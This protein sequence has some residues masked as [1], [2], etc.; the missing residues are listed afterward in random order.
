MADKDT[1]RDPEKTGGFENN[2][3]ETVQEDQIDDLLS[4]DDTQTIDDNT[5]SKDDIKDS[6][7]DKEVVD[8]TVKLK[9]DLTKKIVDQTTDL[10]D[11][12][13]SGQTDIDED[14]N[15]LKSQ[16]K[17][18][19]D[20]FGEPTTID[21]ARN[22][23][24]QQART[25]P[26]NNRNAQD[27]FDS[28][29]IDQQDLID[30]LSGDVDRA[31]PVFRKFLRSAVELSHRNMMQEQARINAVTSYQNTIQGRFYELFPDLSEFRD[32]VFIA[33]NQVQNEIT[34]RGEKIL[35]H[36][37]LELVGKR[38][39]DIIGKIRGGN[40]TTTDN[41]VVRGSRQGAVVANRVVANNREK[42]TDEQKEMYELLED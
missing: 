25:E 42:L 23:Q 33:G 36:E 16:L 12:I 40:T 15:N 35:P 31:V 9:S 21:Q 5:T 18:Y 19:K 37:T 22:N 3:G 26:A 8:R 30:F 4:K 6:K 1:E 17:F 10:E 7:D 2:E 28:Y 14:I 11:K 27:P 29:G 41:K 13:K 20:L 39:R 38:A 34:Q 32:I 24:Q